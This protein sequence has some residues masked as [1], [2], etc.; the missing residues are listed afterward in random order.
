MSDA[1]VPLEVLLVE[2][3][4]VVRKNY[5]NQI[6]LEGWNVAFASDGFEA[7]QAAQDRRFDLVLLDVRTPYK[8][9]PEVL[10]ALRSRAET[11]RAA[12]FL[13]VE[14]GDA[15]I[16]DRALLEGAAGVIEKARTSPREAISEIRTF[17]E[18]GGRAA[19][20]APLT[21]PAVESA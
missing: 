13:L 11:A 5:G 8:S 2:D 17:L 20:Q 3:D 12:V 18:A 16:V 6:R 14:P 1:A 4:P 10:R 9:G 19:A 21:I 15:E 7:L